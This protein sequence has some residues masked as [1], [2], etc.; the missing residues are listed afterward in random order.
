MHHSQHLLAAIATLAAIANAQEDLTARFLAA[1][2]AHDPRSSVE[3]LSIAQIPAT[4]LAAIFEDGSHLLDPA[5]WHHL[6]NHISARRNDLM[7]LGLQI[8]S[9]VQTALAT[10]PNMMVKSNHPRIQSLL[11]QWPTALVASLLTLAGSSQ[12]SLQVLQRRRDESI[13]E[14]V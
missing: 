12:I 6:H 1:T 5:P 7:R 2:S 10:H 9:S 3:A 4:E 14:H 8:P 13:P 11:K